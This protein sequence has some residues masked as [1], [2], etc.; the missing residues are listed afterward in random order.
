MNMKLNKVIILCVAAG[1]LCSC[2]LFTKKHRA[3]VAVEVNGQ[4]LE[5]SE[6]DQLTVGLSAEDS[7]IVADRYIKQWA[8]EVLLYD[9]ARNKVD[10]KHIAALVEDYRRSLYAHAYAER[11]LQRMPKEIAQAEIDSFYTKHQNQY[12][13]KDALVK[14]LLLIVPNG[15]PDLEKVKKEMRASNENNIEFIEKYAYRYATGYELFTDEWKTLSQLS[16]WV[17]MTKA[18]LQK[19]LKPNTLVTMADSVSTYV[20]QVNDIRAV[21]TAMPIEYA[22]VEIEPILLREKGTLLLQNER[23]RI[24]EDAL[25]FKKIHLYE[26]K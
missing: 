6:L 20:L 19:Q 1:M 5:Y 3:G 13:L 9:K 8:T 22:R 23:E 7:A 12:V 18:E 10:D 2:T 17:P 25:R 24:Y 14:G 26:K 15:T 11:L 16:V 4:Y 21:G